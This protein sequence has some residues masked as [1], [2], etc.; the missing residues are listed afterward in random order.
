MGDD[1]LEFDEAVRIYNNRVIGRDQG[2][3]LPQPCAYLSE[4]IDGIWY[5]RNASGFITR[6]GTATS[7]IDSSAKPTALPK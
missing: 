1:E 3:P 5:L 7:R 6:V 4:F 2:E